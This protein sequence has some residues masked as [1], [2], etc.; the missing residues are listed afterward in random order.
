MIPSPREERAFEPDLA[1]RK[2]KRFLCEL[3]DRR[4]ARLEHLQRHKRIHT[5]EKP[6]NCSKCQQRFSRSDL[7]VRHERLSHAVTINDHTHD[8]TQRAKRPCTPKNIDQQE[9]VDAE[10]AGPVDDV[11]GGMTLNE[12]EL[13]ALDTTPQELL[14]PSFEISPVAIPRDVVTIMDVSCPKV[15]DHDNQRQPS[16]PGQGY[17]RPDQAVFNNS[18]QDLAALMDTNS[19]LPEDFLSFISLSDLTTFIP[20]QQSQG[21]ETIPVL[22]NPE[23]VPR[24]D[25]VESFSRL[26][27]RIPSLEPQQDVRPS[28]EPARSSRLFGSISSETRQHFISKLGVFGMVIPGHFQ[29]P[30]KLALSRYFTAYLNAFHEHLPFLNIPTL[31]SETCCIE[32]VLAI[33]SVGAQA[34]LESETAVQL[35]E[36][37]HAIA[38]ERLQRLDDSTTQPRTCVHR[39]GS[40]CAPSPEQYEAR[41]PVPEAPLDDNQKAPEHRIQ[42][43]QALLL[44]MAEATWSNNRRISRQALVIQSMLAGL[45]REDGLKTTLPPPDIRWEQWAKYESMKRTKWIVFCFFNLHTIVYDIPS[46]ILSA[47]MDAMHLPCNAETFRAISKTTWLESKKKETNVSFKRALRGLFKD[48]SRRQELTPNSSLGNYVLIHALIQHIYLIRQVS[49][50]RDDTGSGIPEEDLAS[51]ELA[52][53]NWKLA[54]KK[55]PESS[56]DPANLA[57]PVSFNS[58]ALLRLAYIRLNADIGPNRA[59]HTHDPAKIA[60]AFLQS[61]TII[62]TPGLLRAILHAAHALSIP[63]RIGVHIVAQTQT[64]RWS[65]QHSLATL[66]CAFLLSKWLMALSSAFAD[67]SITAGEYSMLGLVKTIL[68]ETDH[69]LPSTIALESPRGTRTL[70]VNLLR[71]WA[72]SFHGPTHVWAIVDVIAKSLEMCANMIDCG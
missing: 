6:F 43:A 61:K 66:E 5:Q 1:P 41:V 30:S 37:S 58:T 22:L 44:L 24:Q 36:T 38:K 26:G 69:P 68:D 19:P 16:L 71:V 12:F 50:H 9:S 17:M 59:L 32:L 47:D 14:G 72:N 49:H 25:P 18:M 42:T 15:N 51:I 33:A 48:E 10:N 2:P 52:L 55:T 27:S 7:L 62:R 54:W 45:A 57:G 60:N 21:Q 63:I 46:L 34:C 70:A 67:E 3:C 8:G 31:V 23:S 13:S 35:F 64:V 29:M 39:R 56:L 65:I 11:S 53:K 28:T 4:F 40:T 20:P